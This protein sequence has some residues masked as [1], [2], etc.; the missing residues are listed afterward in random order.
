MGILDIL[1]GNSKKSYPYSRKQ[2][3]EG[4]AVRLDNPFVQAYKTEDARARAKQ[5]SKNDVGLRNRAPQSVEKSPATRATQDMALK[6]QGAAAAQQGME[7]KIDRNRQDWRTYFGNLAKHEGMDGRLD[8]KWSDRLAQD[9]PD[10]WLADTIGYKQEQAAA[11]RKGMNDG[12]DLEPDEVTRNFGTASRAATTAQELN[13][14]RMEPMNKRN[15]L[16][17]A[18]E[19]NVSKQLD[20]NKVQ[21]AAV[22]AEAKAEK[23]KSSD[24]EALKQK[25]AARA[26]EADRER[27]W[28][29]REM[30][31]VIADSWGATKKWAK[32]YTKG[33]LES[34]AAKQ[35]GMDS[36]A[37]VLSGEGSFRDLLEANPTSGL[38]I[39]AR[40][41]FGVNDNS[42]E[43]EAILKKPVK[44]KGKEAKDGGDETGS[45]DIPDELVWRGGSY[46]AKT[47]TFIDGGGEKY[48]GD[49]IRQHY[50]AK[51]SALQTYVQG[52]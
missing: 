32:D 9:R 42:N 18:D 5:G 36:A 46:D 8:P 49:I 29:E 44:P 51:A 1:H 43:R 22:A 34:R 20:K 48:R 21:Q 50:G 39:L 17:G 15:A 40:L 11:S 45:G 3:D 37:K 10:S 41:G 14:K 25:L 31:D 4:K 24:L 30:D 33:G 35:W 13:A 28:Y 27:P 12:G 19:A 23:K 38:G 7:A 16:R 2:Y 52:G 26:I 6:A 47:D